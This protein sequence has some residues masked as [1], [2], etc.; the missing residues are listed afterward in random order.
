MSIIINKLE[1]L[2]AKLD[3]NADGDC[4]A[5]KEELLELDEILPDIDSK[6]SRIG[7]YGYKFTIS[8][9]FQ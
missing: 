8:W 6:V 1:I 3:K 7:Y 4:T 9:F 5:I 2:Q